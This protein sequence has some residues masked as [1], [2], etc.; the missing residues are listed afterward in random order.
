M[1]GH[2][3][4]CKTGRVLLPGLQTA[5]RFGPPA[6]SRA[7]YHLD[8]LQKIAKIFTSRDISRGLPLKRYTVKTARRCSSSIF[9]LIC[10]Q[11][12]ST[13]TKC[14]RPRFATDCSANQPLLF[15]QINLKRLNLSR[16][17]HYQI[18]LF[19]QVALRGATSRGVHLEKVSPK[20]LKF[21]V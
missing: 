5:E 15:L 12:K 6:F 7:F 10:H 1:F 19:M 3:S 13:P 4:R 8:M 9:F 20:C 17:S 18:T 21:V 16:R 2:F 14:P 11:L